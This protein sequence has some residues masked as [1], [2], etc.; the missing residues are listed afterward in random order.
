MEKRINDNYVCG[1]I[2]LGNFIR[3]FIR[4][5]GND[6]SIKKSNLSPDPS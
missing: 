1:K 3:D 2:S 5:P 4:I 6:S